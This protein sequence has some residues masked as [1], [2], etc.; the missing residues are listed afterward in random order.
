MT[1]RYII[2]FIVALFVMSACKQNVHE[3][4][5]Q[6]QIIKK[7]YEKRL[8]D[9]NKGL[10]ARDSSKILGV[11]RANNWEMDVTETGLWY[12]IIE[13]GNGPR[14]QEGQIAEL[15][16]EVRLL[17]GQLAYT[18]DS[19]GLLRFRLSKGGVERGLEE[20]VLLLQQGD[21]ARFIM[22]PYMAHNLLG[23]Q[24]RIPPRSIIIYEVRLISLEK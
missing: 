15:D 7:E 4:R 24:K 19:T 10:V 5:Q 17:N 22:P 2:L 9:A 11:V 20:G 6:Q 13:N 16:Y 12:Q 14:A 21:S 18:A 1:F 8:I 3:K 23:D